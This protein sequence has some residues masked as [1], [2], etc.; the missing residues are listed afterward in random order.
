MDFSAIL[1]RAAGLGD[2]LSAYFKNNIKRP[3]PS[4]GGALLDVPIQYGDFGSAALDLST[5][6]GSSEF[7]TSEDPLE[8]ATPQDALNML[9]YDDPKSKKEV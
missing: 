6:I 4:R 2:E 5:P 8:T 7:N 9:V 3:T 1:N